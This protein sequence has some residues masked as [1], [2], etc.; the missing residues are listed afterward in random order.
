LGHEKNLR[1][2][3]KNNR[4]LTNIFKPMRMIKRAKALNKPLCVL[5]EAI[6]TPTRAKRTVS[7][8]T[9]KATRK[10]T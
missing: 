9:N 1:F 5:F 8:A 3:D 2:R 7:G 6:L 10:L 4:F